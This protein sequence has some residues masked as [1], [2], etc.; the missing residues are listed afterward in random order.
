[1]ARHLVLLVLI[2]GSIVQPTRAVENTYRWESAHF[3]FCFITDDGTIHNLAWA[4][5][6]LAMDFR[7]TIAVNSGRVGWRLLTDENVHE[8]QESGFEIANHSRTHGLAGL[9]PD[10]PMPPAGSL[11]GYWECAVDPSEAMVSFQAEIERDSLAE[12]AETP[13]EEIRTFAYPRHMHTRAIID[14]LVSEGYLGARQAENSSFLTYSNGDFTVPARNSWSG[15]IS[16]F[17]VPLAHYC[18]IFFGDHSA[19]PPVHFSYEEF[20][21]ATLPYVLDARER[22]GIFALYAHHCGDDDDSMGDLNYGS[23]GITAEELGW[24]IDLVREFGGRVMTFGDAVSYYQSRTTMNEI[25][26]DLV[27]APPTAASPI[28]GTPILDHLGAYPNPFNPLTEIHFTVDRESDVVV[29]VFDAAGR[30]VR[31]LGPDHFRA[32]SHRTRWDG[33]DQRGRPLPSGT[34]FGRIEAGGQSVTRPMTLLR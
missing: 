14:G 12:F 4:D 9:P 11:L 30:R 27:W 31:L 26:G 5:Q 23:G 21:A 34:Y 32:G 10:C 20:R 24:I 16:L 28:A 1:M 19:I 15:G 8:L 18:S 7:F 13:V 25:D 6:G 33:R 22:G 2:F 3:V 29:S 17:R